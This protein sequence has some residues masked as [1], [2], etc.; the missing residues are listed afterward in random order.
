VQLWLNGVLL[1]LLSVQAA[2]LEFKQGVQQLMNST[3]N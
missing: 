3:V 2:C 1:L